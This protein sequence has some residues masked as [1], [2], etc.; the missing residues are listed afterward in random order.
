MSQFNPPP[1]GFPPPMGFPPQPAGFQRPPQPMG[2]PPQPPM[3]GF[4]GEPARPGT[5]WMLF[6]IV[7]LLGLGLGF[8]AGTGF[9]FG[10]GRSAVGGGPAAARAG[11]IFGSQ[12][13][14]A[15]L[16]NQTMSTVQTLRSQLALYRLQHSDNYPTLEQLQD[17]WS[18]F[19]S[20]TDA[21]GRPATGRG[22][23]YGPYMQSRP[24]NPLNNRTEVCPMSAPHAEAGW[25]YD[26]DTGQIKA[27]APFGSA[28][29]TMS[30][31][32]VVHVPR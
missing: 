20:Q 28:G 25:A 23:A 22:I 21:Q 3:A 8:A 11:T 6:V 31:D 14:G 27:I 26:P 18:V 5:P 4:G 1:Q 29:N 19:V 16:A 17:G 32:L 12:R 7:A 24:V 9:G 2:I 15:A 10:L 30:T 13:S